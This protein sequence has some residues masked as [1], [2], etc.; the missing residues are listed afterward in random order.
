VR[1]K[2]TKLENRAYWV[3]VNRRSVALARN[4]TNAAVPRPTPRYSA[5][6]ATPR[7]TGSGPIWASAAKALATGLASDDPKLRAVSAELFGLVAPREAL[8]PLV[9]A[10]GRGDKVERSAVR[11]AAAR[12]SRNAPPATLDA[13]LRQHQG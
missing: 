7:A 11:A 10:L 3:A 4:A 9:A 6:T 12:A 8:S 2:A 5:A 13:F 1:G